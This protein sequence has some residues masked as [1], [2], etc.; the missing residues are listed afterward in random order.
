MVGVPIGRFERQ[1]LYRQILI[2]TSQF[3]DPVAA[4]VV[5][6]HVRRRFEETKSAPTLTRLRKY[7]G[8]GRRNLH[9]I[10]AANYGDK[11]AICKFLGTGYARQGKERHEALS[12][13]LYAEHDQSALAGPESKLVSVIGP[14]LKAVMAAH[15]PERVREGKPKLPRQDGYNIALSRIKNLEW[16]YHRSLLA[17]LH[18]PMRKE[19]ANRLVDI[20]TGKIV[21]TPRNTFR[22]RPDLPKAANPHNLSER[23]IRH[24]YAELLQNVPIMEWS[25]D[26]HK[27]YWAPRT[28]ELIG[29]ADP[30]DTEVLEA[31]ELQTQAEEAGDVDDLE[32]EPDNV[33]TDAEQSQIEAGIGDVELDRAHQ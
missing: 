24:I 21:L 13:L 31:D 5:E 19:E 25:S 23:F 27:V 32:T 9:K 26:M 33:Q 16:K 10:Q 28:A 2:A 7:L 6:K 12:K 18:V 17:R 1:Q 3:F 14:P 11:K 15:S 29:E 4:K 8:E 22:T 20:A 30:K